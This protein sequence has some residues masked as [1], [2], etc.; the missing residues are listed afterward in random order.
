[1][2]YVLLMKES[3]GLN[4]RSVELKSL[5]RYAFMISYS[6]THYVKALCT[7]HTYCTYI[8]PACVLSYTIL[9]GCMGV[10]SLSFPYSQPVLLY[11][12][13][14]HEHRYLKLLQQYDV[15][16]FWGTYAWAL[17]TL[18][19]TALRSYGR[20]YWNFLQN[21]DNNLKLDDRS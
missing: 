18:A 4:V 2:N 6:T 13:Y 1:M 10:F 16:F 14:V 3:A 8:T 21:F 11:V 5:V 17:H 12:L 20:K 19:F 7:Y 9:D 15:T